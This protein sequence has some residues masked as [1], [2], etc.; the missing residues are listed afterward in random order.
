MSVIGRLIGRAAVDERPVL[1]IVEMQRRHLREVLA[2]E[3]VSYPRPWT[4]RVFADEL[5]MMRRGERLYLAALVGRSL[6]GYGGILF[7][8]DSAHVTNLAVDPDWRRRGVAAE[9]LLEL[10][11][12]AREQG[13]E[14]LSLEVR[15][16]NHA[17]QDLYRRFG[18]APAGVRPR[19][20]EGV[21]DAIVMWC[22]GVQDDEFAERLGSI[23]RERS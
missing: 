13:V 20:Y 23:E 17:A 7:A 9:V 1:R 21:D 3:E 16:S 22:H 5:E 8:G 15:V 6:V 4:P 18:F 2:I 19:Y 11:W 14:A 10:A 12:R